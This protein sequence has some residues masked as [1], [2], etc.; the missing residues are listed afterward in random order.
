MGSGGRGVLCYKGV[1]V[2]K[3]TAERFH[4]V[5]SCKVSSKLTVYKKCKVG[6]NLKSD[7][8][9]RG[10][11]FK[12]DNSIKSPVSPRLWNVNNLSR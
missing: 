4:R 3:G 12:V 9:R 11:Q 6:V 10:S 1:D 8:E 7:E 5:F 2:N